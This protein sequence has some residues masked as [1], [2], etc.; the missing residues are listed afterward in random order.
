MVLHQ[1]YWWSHLSNAHLS[2]TGRD[3]G[4]ILWR[5]EWKVHTLEI[6]K[7]VVTQELSNGS[8]LHYPNYLPP[9]VCYPNHPPPGRP[10]CLLR[11][12][13][14]LP[15]RYQYI[16]VLCSKSDFVVLLAPH[17]SHCPPAIR[18]GIFAPLKRPWQDAATGIRLMK[19][20]H[21]QEVLCQSVSF[22]IQECDEAQ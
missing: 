10:V 12:W 2:C 20:G 6:L 11:T 19:G 5:V 15:H 9:A 4:T 13:P 14:L 8:A 16:E 1:H 22:C 18:H 3:L 7:R 17:T 21:Q